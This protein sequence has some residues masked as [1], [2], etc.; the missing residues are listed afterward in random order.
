MQ[1]LL[2]PLV[3]SFTLLL[4]ILFYTSRYNAAPKIRTFLDRGG[5]V[6]GSVDSAYQGIQSWT[7]LSEIP[8]T[9]I[10]KTIRQEDRF[11]YWHRGVNPFAVLKAAAEN[12]TRRRFARGGSTITQQLA[13]NLMQERACRAAS[14]CAPLPRT[15]A[16][17]FRETLL[18]LGLEAK[19][20]KAWILERYLNSIYYGRRAYGIAAAASVY[21]GDDLNELSEAKM[22]FLVARPKAPNRRS[23]FPFKDDP[24]FADKIPG[25]HFLEFVSRSQRFQDPENANPSVI[26]TLDVN[27]QS[28]LE[29]ATAR[30][31]A[32]RA[33]E[34]PKLTAAVVVIDVRSGDVLAMVGSR[35][36]FNE[37]IDGQVNAATALRQ[38]GSALKPFTYFAAF[39][40]GFGPDSIVP[41]EPLSFTA[42]GLGA[43]ESE[44][45]APQ[46]F[47]RLYHGNM[48]IR[49]ALA[50]SYNVPA[51]VTLNQIG[52]SYYHEILKKF[53]ITTLHRSPM[54]YGLSVTLGSGE[55]TL[56]ELTNAYAAL[57]RG[58]LSLPYRFLKEENPAPTSPEA[59]MPNASF[60]ASQVTNILSDPQARLKAFGFNDHM[61]VEG[62]NA[63]I[64]TGTS[65][66]HR[67]NWAL[68]YSPSYA[69]GVWVGHADGSPIPL[70]EN[71]GVSTGA[72][73][74]APLWHAAMEILLRA[75]PPEFFA[76]RWGASGGESAFAPRFEPKHLALP[77]RGGLKIEV[78]VA[79]SVYRVHSY[80]PL[81]HQ[82]ILARVT[83]APE[84]K[85]PLRWYLDGRSLTADSRVSE[86]WIS[87]EEGRHEL[88]VVAD[89]GE[90]QSVSFRVLKEN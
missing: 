33:L 65:Y 14:S 10:D 5:R 15:F 75:K 35:D 70:D 31:L 36:Y 52:L 86:V 51:V 61:T 57:A 38:P 41:D 2:P 54:Y 53:G 47:D 30:L 23:S 7:P 55:V 90:T 67:D 60:Y 19:H 56:L 66:E 40:K 42:V 12:I 77:V 58:G 71:G 8:E 49:Q 11:F 22:D 13:K 44:A 59:V 39:A 50:N 63:A 74:A 37:E 64:K 78:P 9:L 16:N 85:S 21:F 6:I 80:L 88:Q 79:N 81:A 4:F 46:N 72:S 34:D 32:S 76:S 87:P 45:Y 3:I 89:N 18:A 28:Q 20:S 84:Q 69:V 83:F 62:H 17:K 1:K 24:A 82:K 48:T 73:G 68:G 26:T 43:D 29:T 25:R 27:L